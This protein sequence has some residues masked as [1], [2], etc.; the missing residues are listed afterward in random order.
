MNLSDHDK[1]S[2]KRLS[3]KDEAQFERQGKNQTE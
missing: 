3:A 1:P 2:C